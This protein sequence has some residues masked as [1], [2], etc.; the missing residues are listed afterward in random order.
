MHQPC[1]GQLLVELCDACRT[2]MPESFAM[3]RDSGALVS[4]A[5]MSVD[6]AKWILSVPTSHRKVFEIV[7]Q[8]Y[9]SKEV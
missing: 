2:K 3:L 8:G 6:A 9:F 5:H 1:L 7:L 4:I